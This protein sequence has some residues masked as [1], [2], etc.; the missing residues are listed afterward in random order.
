MPKN[1]D[2]LTDDQLPVF[3]GLC[4]LLLWMIH[5]L[6]PDFAVRL[7]TYIVTVAIIQAERAR[8]REPAR[9]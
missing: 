8:T 1:L 5:D 9:M 3:E 4:L 7:R 6:D 2:T